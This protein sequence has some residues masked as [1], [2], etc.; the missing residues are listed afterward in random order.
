MKCRCAICV[1]LASFY[2]LKSKYTKNNKHSVENNLHSNSDVMS[3]RKWFY[4]TT[5]IFDQK[6]QIGKISYFLIKMLSIEP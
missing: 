1:F 6:C 2:K 3:L 4:I 5:Y